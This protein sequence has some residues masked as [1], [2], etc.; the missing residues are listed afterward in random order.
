MT[1]RKAPTGLAPTDDLIYETLN[2][3]GIAHQ[4]L[5][6]RAN[7][8]LAEGDLP[9]P[10]FVLLSH[11]TKDPARVR[12]VSGIAAAFQAP[13]PGITKTIAKLHR[14]GFVDMR[15]STSDKRVR[16]V[17]VT[18]AGLTAFRAALKLLTPDTRLIFSE[19]R[20]NDI[21]ALHD[22]LEKLKTWLD[23]NRELRPVA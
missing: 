6:T 19:W 5:T 11:F 1:S 14:R 23:E 17:Y 9:F 8:R 3:I 20:K 2:F 16:E 12:T 22:H 13:Q 21:A 10:Q 15:P 4:L 18:T 7:R